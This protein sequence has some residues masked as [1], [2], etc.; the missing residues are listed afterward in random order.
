MMELPEAF[1]VFIS[2]D[3]FSVAKIRHRRLVI[4]MRLVRRLCCI[5]CL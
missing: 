1:P 4:S 3:Y 2:F 5:E